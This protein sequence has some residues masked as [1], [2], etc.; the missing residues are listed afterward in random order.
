MENALEMLGKL[1]KFDLNNHAFGL[2]ENANSNFHERFEIATAQREDV[3]KLTAQVK[4]D[5]QTNSSHKPAW[6]SDDSQVRY[7][8]PKERVNKHLNS[9]KRSRNLHAEKGLRA[10]NSSQGTGTT[11]SQDNSAS[12]NNASVESSDKSA[13]K[14]LSVMDRSSID[15]GEKAKVLATLQNISKLTSVR[16]PNFEKV[17]Q[18]LLSVLTG[19][20]GKSG[21]SIE[22]PRNGQGSSTSTGENSTSKNVSEN[23]PASL[24]RDSEYLEKIQKMK[25]NALEQVRYQMRMLVKKGIGEINISLKPHV[26]GNVKINLLIEASSASAHFVVENNT[27]KELLQDNLDT[28][29]ASF[30][31]KGMDIQEIDVSVSDHNDTNA[32]NGKSFTSVE[33]QQ[34]MKEWIRSFYSYDENNQISPTEEDP[35]EE[36]A[37]IIDSDELLNIIA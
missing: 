20:D 10:R 30:S 1:K 9:E 28:L 19:T 2:L 17:S 12:V 33:D 34:T 3:E 35:D 31:N 25:S 37:Q 23:K 36:Q 22:L 11:S 27:V 29:R 32:G 13:D 16:N 7:G 18:K 24:S 14:L 6:E 21:K 4:K 15:P 26:L 8:N 5:S